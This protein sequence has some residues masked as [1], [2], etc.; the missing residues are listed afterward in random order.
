MRTMVPSMPTHTVSSLGPCKNSFRLAGITIILNAATHAN[1]RSAVTSFSSFAP[2][3]V[4]L[5]DARC[6]KKQA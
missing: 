1:R 5:A 2:S 4:Q 3:F 6:A